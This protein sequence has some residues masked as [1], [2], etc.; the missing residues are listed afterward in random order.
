MSLFHTGN[1]YHKGDNMMIVYKPLTTEEIKIDLFAHFYRRQKVTE[2]YR[3]IDGIWQIKEC[4]FIDD[5]TMEEYQELTSCL[6]HTLKTNGYVLGAFLDKQLKGFVSVESSFFGEN[7]D[8][9]DLSSLHVSNDMRQQGIGKKLFCSA[10]NWAKK[11]GAKKLY[12]SS[13]SAV[14]TQ[15]FYQAMGCV[16]AMEINEMH[17]ISEP[18]DRQLECL[19]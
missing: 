18:F 9:L 8:Y 2:C 7:R 10:K 3:F 11:R 15:S 5:W 6:Q 14:E 19:L 4:P 12:I 16:D 13:H 1:P 17:V